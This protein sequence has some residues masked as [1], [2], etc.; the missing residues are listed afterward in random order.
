MKQE[1]LL[2]RN[3]LVQAIQQKLDGQLECTVP[4]GGLNLWCKIL[5]KVDANELL[6]KAIQRGI[7]FVPGGVY[8]STNHYVRFS[9]AQPNRD[10]LKKGI[11]IFADVLGG[12]Q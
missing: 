3:I 12:C 8:G 5:R 9:Y 6:E 2:K 1:L 7:V 4:N 11:S 10:S